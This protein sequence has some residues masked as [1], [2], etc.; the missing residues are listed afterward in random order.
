MLLKGEKRRGAGELSKDGG[1]DGA[2][3]GKEADEAAQKMKRRMREMGKLGL[4][5]GAAEF[6]IA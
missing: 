2:E 3:V 1:K 5:G 6:N 4:A